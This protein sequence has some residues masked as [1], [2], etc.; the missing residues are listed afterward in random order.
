VTSKISLGIEELSINFMEN[1]SSKSKFLVKCHLI[2]TLVLSQ[3]SSRD[4]ER[5]LHDEFID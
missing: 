1:L 4:M 2:K 5:K 3:S